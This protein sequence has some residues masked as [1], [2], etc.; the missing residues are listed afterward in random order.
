[1]PRYENFPSLHAMLLA[2]SLTICAARVA[3]A[4]SEANGS[5]V[6]QNSTAAQRLATRYPTSKSWSVPAASRL[7]GLA[8]PMTSGIGS[9]LG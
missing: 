2:D 3:L 4:R 8:I 1:M 6:N 9:A 7:T 5:L